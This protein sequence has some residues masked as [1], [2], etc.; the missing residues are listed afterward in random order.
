MTDVPKPRKRRK[1]LWIVGGILAAL[2][3][4]VIVA[5]LSPGDKE[6]QQASD[7]PTAAAV[8]NDATAKPS[9]TPIPSKTPK[10]TNTPKPTT[11]PA[12]TPVPT[13]TL[14]PSETPA[15]SPTATTEPPT[16]EP[17]TATPIPPTEAPTMAPTSAPAPVS[18]SLQVHFI[19]VGQGDAILIVAPDGKAALIDGGESGSGVLAYLRALGVERLDLVIAT[20]P[21]ADH[22]GGLVDVLNGIPVAEVVTSGQ[23]HTT[24]TYE[25][26]LDGIAAAQAI[27]TEVGRGDSLQL[28]GLTLDVLHPASAAGDD[29]NNASLVLRLAYGQVAF[30]F[31]GDAEAQTEAS[32]LA[33][34]YDVRA[35]ILKVGHHGSRTSSSATFLARVQPEVAVYCAGAGNSYGHPHGETLAA[36]TQSGAQVYGTD[37]HG[38]VI[39]TTDGTGYAVA[40]AQP[41]PPRAPPVVDAPQ[42]TTVSQ[43]AQ[44]PAQG[45]CA[46]IGNANSKVFHHPGCGSVKQMSEKN[47]VCLSSRDEA[48]ASGYRPCQ[49]CNP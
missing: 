17:P 44:P 34:G 45:G 21:H 4:C 19:D 9:K 10:P 7:K 46:Y 49:K 5:A 33:A 38:T 23:M 43:P 6:S 14:A 31:T 37:T 48:I 16:P 41:A 8:S 15:P 26:F 39:V 28:G 30:L 40:V 24:R 1:L 42:P 27:Y 20:H 3:L 36:L 29:F 35:N 12:D 2:L 11:P 22:I 32:I 25:R 18:G 47:K 13:E